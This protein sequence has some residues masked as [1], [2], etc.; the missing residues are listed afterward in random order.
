MASVTGVAMI[1]YVE[2]LIFIA[3]VPSVADVSILIRVAESNHA[4]VG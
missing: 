4:R 2:I 3:N 1:R